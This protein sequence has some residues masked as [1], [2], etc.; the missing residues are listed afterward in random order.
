ML[1]AM[2]VAWLLPILEEREALAAQMVSVSAALPVVLQLVALVVPET[3]AQEGQEGLVLRPLL[4]QVATALNLMPA[5]VPVEVV[6]ATLAV[7][8]GQEVFME[9]VVAVA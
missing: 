1:A 3:M 5:T 7:L 4:T 6:A 2:V 9:A 8:V